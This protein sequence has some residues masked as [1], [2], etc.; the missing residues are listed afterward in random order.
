MMRRK[1]RL[2]VNIRIDTDT[3]AKHPNI[4]SSLCAN[5]TARVHKRNLIILYT[6]GLIPPLLKLPMRSRI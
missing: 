6:I 2:G 3:G 1:A 4:V 5:N